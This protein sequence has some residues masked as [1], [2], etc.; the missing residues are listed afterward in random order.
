MNESECH[1]KS[2]II[3]GD[4]TNNLYNLKNEKRRRKRRKRARGGKKRRNKVKEER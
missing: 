2:V 1:R 4:K 3:K